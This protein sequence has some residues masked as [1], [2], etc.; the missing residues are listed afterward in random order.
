[1]SQLNDRTGQRYGRLTVLY[2]GE[3][4]VYPN[5]RKVVQ[6]VCQCDCGNQTTVATTSLGQGLTQS[7]GCL[8]DEKRKSSETKY[9]KHGHKKERIYET[10]HGMKQRCLNS[11]SDKYEL[12][13]GR[14]ITICEEWKNDFQKFY[15]WAMANGYNDSLTIDRIDVDKGYCPENCRWTNA[16]IQ[17]RNKRD[18]KLITFNGETHCLAEWAEITGINRSTI[19]SRIDKSGWSVEDALTKPP[20][21]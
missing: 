16:K 12:Y 5:G 15:D 2:R 8:N 19:S 21:K 14:G 18:N 10:W 6:W 3:D 13:G 11:N 9:K 20:C 1:M 4:K 17:Q 7:C